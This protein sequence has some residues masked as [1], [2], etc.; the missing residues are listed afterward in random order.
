M[1]NI[2]AE[3]YQETAEQRLLSRLL[4]RKANRAKPLVSAL[5]PMERM[6]YN[7]LDDPNDRLIYLRKLDHLR[8][9]G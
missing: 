5:T 4:S 8:M 3:E 1:N 6:K 9:E 2:F 7:A